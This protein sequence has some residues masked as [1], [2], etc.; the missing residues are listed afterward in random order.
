M[1]NSLTTQI[2][3]VGLAD[4]SVMIKAT[5][6]TALWESLC[7]INLIQSLMFTILEELRLV[8]TMQ[9]L[10]TVNRISLA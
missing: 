9:Q 5:P 4:A 1:P 2:C 7:A 6:N 8:T 10:Q 3:E